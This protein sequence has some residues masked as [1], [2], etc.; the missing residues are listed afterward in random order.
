MTDRFQNQLRNDSQ[1]SDVLSRIDPLQL[2]ADAEE[3]AAGARCLQALQQRRNNMQDVDRMVV[4][5]VAGS[6]RRTSSR[7]LT[8][9]DEANF[10]EIYDRH[11]R[12][13]E[14]IAAEDAKQIVSEHFETDLFQELLTQ[15]EQERLIRDLQDRRSGWLWERQRRLYQHPSFT[16]IREFI[17]GIRNNWLLRPAAIGVALMAYNIAVAT[18]TFS[19]G[20]LRMDRIIVVVKELPSIPTGLMILTTPFLPRR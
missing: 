10:G 14:T 4:D 7:V 12:E 20:E 15:Y 19:D 16:R 1:L 3:L 11:R 8:H 5:Y 17:D 6:I 13:I 9:L 2:L 18:S